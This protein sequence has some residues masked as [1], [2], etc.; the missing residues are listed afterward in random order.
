MQFSVR[1]VLVDLD[2]T[3]VDSTG[4]IVRSWVRFAGEY[5]IGVPELVAARGHGRRSQDVIAD[6]VAEPRRAA[7]FDRVHA[8]ELADTDD[9]TPVPGAAALLAALPPSSWGIVTSGSRQLAAARL[10]AAG[11]GAHVDRLLVTGDD[12]DAGKPDP[13]PY[14]AGAAALGLAPGDCLAVEDAAAGI[15]SAAAAG[16]AKLAVTITTPARD[17]PADAVVSDLTAVTISVAA[18]GGRLVVAVDTSQPVRD[19]VEVPTDAP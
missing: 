4:A 6:L 19:P 11:L 7:A 2:G 18:A 16:M 5:G 1:G 17:L 10:R 3:V 14:L 13:A 9:L 12:V 8:L 15:A